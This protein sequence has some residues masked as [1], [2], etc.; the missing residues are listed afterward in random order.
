MR[1]GWRLPK[2]A[3]LAAVVL[4]G[5]SLQAVV[6]HGA[7]A[8]STS[9]G[10]ASGPTDRPWQTGVSSGPMAARAV[11]AGPALLV[12]AN[13][14]VPSLRTRSSQTFERSGVMKTVVA[15][16]PVNY[17]D[18]SGDWLPIDDSLVKQAGG[19]YRN[20]ADDFSVSIPARSASATVASKDAV[21]VSS[22]LVGGADVPVVAAGNRATYATVM[23]GVDA[24]FDVRPDTIEETLRL[25][26][27]SVPRSYTWSVTLSHGVS[28]RL[29]ADRA[30]SLI[31]SAGTVV[32]SLPAPVLRDSSTDPD[33]STSTAAH[34]TITGTAPQYVVTISID[35]NWLD[36]PARVFPVS[37]DPS[38][39]FGTASDL[40]CYV[41]SPGAGDSTVCA[42]N[43]GTD[44][45]LLYGSTAYVRHVYLN[46][47]DLTAAGSAV[48]AD[49][50][51]SDARLRLTEANASSPT[52]PLPT[53]IYRPVSAWSSS[54]TYATQPANS[55]TQF[56]NV[57]VVPPGVNN[58]TDFHIP[59]LVAAWVGGGVP[60]YGLELKLTTDAVSNTL[61]FYGLANATY[62]PTL[63]VT[64]QQ[65]VGQQAWIAAYDHRVSD[66]LDLHVDL[67]DRNL[68]VNDLA[69]QLSGPGQSLLVRHTYNSL[70]AA[71]GSSGG[72]G[73]GWLMNGG[74]DTGLTINRTVVA[75]TQPGGAQAEFTRNFTVTNLTLP[76]AFAPPPGLNAK[77]TMPD[78]THYTVT[79]NKTKQV[80]TFTLPAA[81][82]TTG[83]LSSVADA[84]GNT[85]SYTASGSPL[86]TT[87]ITDTTGSRSASLSYT[88]GK[89]TG[90]TENLASGTPRS[91]SYTYDSSGRLSTYVDAAGEVTRYCYSGATNLLSKLITARGSA[92]GA[93]CSTTMGTDVIDIGYDSGG[94]VT[95]ISYENGT[96]AAI[97]VTFATQTALTAG[98]TGVTRFTDPYNQHTD[99]T[100]DTADRVT[101]IV[102]PL[103]NTR[104]TGYSLN[105][106]VTASVTPN[107]YTGGGSDPKTTASYDPNSNLTAVTLPTGASVSATYTGAQTYLPNTITDDLGTGTTHQTTLSYNAAGQPTSVAKGAATLTTIHDGEGSPTQHC[108]PSGAA[109]YP[110]A[111]CESRDADYNASLPAEHRTLYSYDSLGELVSTTPPQPDHSRA[112]P[113]NVTATYDGQSRIISITSSDGDV[114]GFHYDALD[115]LIK[116]DVPGFGPAEFVYDEDGNQLSNTDYNASH[117][118]QNYDNY[119][120]DPLNRL[121]TK[122]NWTA[123]TATLT[124]DG[125]SR[126]SSYDDPGGTVSYGYDAAGGLT[127][128]T[129]PGGSCAG[130]SLNPAAR[131]PP[132]TGSGCTL[133]RL[134]KSGGRLETVHPGDVADQTYAYDTSGR[135]VQVTGYTVGDGSGATKTFDNSYSY[136]STGVPGG[137]DTAH[138]IRRTDNLTG[139]YLAYSY[140]A[141]TRLATAIT[142][143]SGGTTTASWTYCYDS[144]A[145]L[146]LATAT[147]GASCPGAAGYT[148]DGANEILTSPAG[149]DAYD[150]DGNETQA[151]STAT[152]TN[153][154]RTTG[155]TRGDQ[156]HSFNV[157]GA[158]A[159]IQLHFGIDNTERYT[160]DISSTDNQAFLTSPLGISATTRSHSGTPQNP[161]YYTRDPAGNLIGMRLGS[162][163]YYYQTDNQQSVLRLLDA[164]GAVK[165]TYTYDP[166]GAQTATA[167]V[168]QPFGYA[169]GYLDDPS[170]LIKFGT[171]Y[172]DPTQ[173]RFTQP[174]P[175]AHPG[176]V[177]QT[178]P[179]PYASDDP[180]NHTD[181]TG[182]L[183]NTEIIVGGALIAATGGIGLAGAG[184][185]FS[186]VGA[187]ELVS[188]LGIATIG[189]G[190]VISTIGA[191]SA[192]T[193]CFGFC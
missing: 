54:I 144:N 138:I 89:V 191:V 62:H 29:E 39:T 8:A 160:S 165:N 104:T 97:T 5:S 42:A 103:G 94:H 159:L 102:N 131:V 44:N 31:D 87:A 113:A 49:A 114:T 46:F 140:S 70:L 22:R 178:S 132:T 25:A 35:G 81:G 1:R 76:T 61:F 10:R 128:L 184:A 176:D 32:G 127:S 154:S 153:Q 43:T 162:T 86:V 190:A 80:D 45:Q 139:N 151:D 92:T 67:A 175:Q 122:Q 136:S 85:I 82:A 7:V 75:L 155:Y 183:S 126:L 47:G 19:G 16:M 48:P 71:S 72:Y 9:A 189:V 33:T 124:W 107:D 121:A 13:G 50:V 106:D 137:A 193:S 172:Y 142:K 129:E 40:G 105:D 171:R 133:F 91:W 3:L 57:S 34:Y 174:D 78:S 149:T 79:F 145:N 111:V 179:Y 60:N 24:V 116:I 21:S 41:A 52:T 186:L 68:V 125:N 101:K 77:M 109:A 2:I 143:T 83:W 20:A 157:G 96:G 100:Y 180:T 27:P 17:R 192:A 11:P 55:G 38:T 88:G 64:W 134:D 146:T 4:V 130:F 15:T 152:G 90:M 115:R 98:G 37:L 156:V 173:A 112:T 110:G 73:P 63:T 148:Y 147:I 167:S 170:G 51:I 182:Q 166:Y 18:A 58:P 69:E 95:S 188:E 56:D 6:V 168:V 108:G 118:A 59:G 36:D 117:V 28:L 177:N 84:N 141:E 53:S 119:T 12:N 185:I 26:S 135:T 65:P 150:A 163:H 93:T 161:K 66:R 123:G 14:E 30:A 158:G 74:V 120:Y 187:G 23:P 99:Y 164:T 181:P 169:S